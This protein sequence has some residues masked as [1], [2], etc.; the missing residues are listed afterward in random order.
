[1]HHCDV[2]A[3]WR[4]CEVSDYN[5]NFVNFMRSLNCAPFCDC[6]CRNCFSVTYIRSSCFI[7]V[8][9]AV[10]FLVFTFTISGDRKFS[11]WKFVIMNFVIG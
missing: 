6:L 4:A 8:H 10:M 1:V 11:D 7:W 3:S 2:S 5:R 9:Y